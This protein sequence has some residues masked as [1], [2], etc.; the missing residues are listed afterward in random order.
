MQSII[1][2][3]KRRLKNM[4]S[5]FWKPA[6][7]SGNY[8]ENRYKSGNNSGAGSYNVLAEFKAEVLNEF[9][10]REHI[11]SVI[12]FGSGDG[13]QLKYFNFKKY[14]GFDISKTAVANC[15]KIYASDSS[16][17]F[18]TVA[19]YKDEKADLTLSLDVLYHLVEYEVYHNYLNLLFNSSTKFVIV[20]S[21]NDDNHENNNVS[22]HVK[23]REF[24][25]WVEQN[26]P[27]FNLEQFIPN[28][29]PY[30]GNNDVSSY[31]DFYIFKKA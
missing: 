31:A 27:E 7:S 24:T 16:K 3:I 14:L 12:E 4:I 28:K 5:I 6:F 9:T 1:Y 15:R 29:Y 11:Q 18:Q 2:K 30:M 20:Y 22:P 8:W 19:N 13:N 26:K 17:S 21:S 10:E 23:H 25:K